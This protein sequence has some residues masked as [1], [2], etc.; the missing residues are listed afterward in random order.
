[1]LTYVKFSAICS[2]Y[3]HVYVIDDRFGNAS[4]QLEAG[5]K[6][7][8]LIFISDSLMHYRIGR[9]SHTHEFE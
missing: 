6:E 4:G 1:M 9:R 5:F 8:F 7:A 2:V 3:I